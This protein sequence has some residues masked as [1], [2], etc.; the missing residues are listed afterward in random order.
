MIAN[1]KTIITEDAIKEWFQGLE[2]YLREENAL[3]IL[4]ESDRL[5]NADETGV[6]LCPKAGKLLGPTT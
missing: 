1:V 5:Y 2:N 4:Q 3:D 6:Q